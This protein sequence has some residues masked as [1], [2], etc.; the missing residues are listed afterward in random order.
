MQRLPS[1][2]GFS[3]GD[4][5]FMISSSCTCRVSVHPTPQYGQIVA[6]V[7]C[8]SGFHSPAARASYSRFAIIAPGGQTAMQFPQQT[9]AESES[10]SANAREHRASNPRTA[11]LL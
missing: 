4:V 2:I 10:G 11:H 1:V 6:T 5:A 7:F 8:S 3:S 9:H